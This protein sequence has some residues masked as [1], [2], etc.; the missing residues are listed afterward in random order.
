LLVFKSFI[1]FVKLI[2]INNTVIII[3]IIMDRPT[4]EVAPCKCKA[5]SE[6]L[7]MHIGRT[8]TCV[9]LP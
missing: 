2:F 5:N 1:N 9:D 4:F 7:V 3:I 6:A 8:Q